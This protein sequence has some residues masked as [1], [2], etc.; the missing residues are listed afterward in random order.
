MKVITIREL[1]ETKKKDLALSLVTEPE[2]LNK[3]SAHS[4]LIGQV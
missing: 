3:N 1:F 2:T 4:L